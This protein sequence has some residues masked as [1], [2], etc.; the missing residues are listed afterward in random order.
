[1]LTEEEI[2][3][4]IDPKTSLDV[5]PKKIENL[6]AMIQEGALDWDVING[7]EQHSQEELDAINIRIGNLIVARAAYE[8]RLTNIQDATKGKPNLPKPQAV[9]PMPPTE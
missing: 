9:P 1:M 6:T 2:Q 3:D 5:L 4:L 8:E 7:M